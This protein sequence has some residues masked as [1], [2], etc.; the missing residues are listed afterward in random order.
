VSW[1]GAGPGDHVYLLQRGG[2]DLSIWTS[3]GEEVG[4]LFPNQLAYPHSVRI[5]RL[6][7]GENRIWITDMPSPDQ[8]VVP[9][10]HC[11]KEFDEA[12]QLL[13]TIGRCGADT[14]GSGLDPVQFD[15]VTDIAF[16]SKG[17][18]WI[19][20]GDIGGLNNRV[21]QLNA[22]GLVLQ[23]WSA[24][25]NQPGSA[26]GQFNLPHALDIDACDRVFIADTLNHRVQVIRT[27]GTFLQQLQC[28]GADGVYGLRLSKAAGA[29]G[30]FLATTSSPTS[31][32]TGGTVRLFQVAPSCTAPLPMP[33]GC[34]T[35]AQ[36]TVTLPPSPVTAL[37][38]SIDVGADGG[39]YIATLGG[40]LPPQKWI[41]V[42]ASRPSNTGNEPGQP[43]RER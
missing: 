41:P 15:K 1:L 36:W 4:G 26:P 20:D 29:G 31:S 11:V 33:D 34:M 10:G 32:P 3:A 42:E 30:A 23:V 39:L 21:L 17:M 12:G 14:G 13:S 25:G 9:V 18:R 43:N 24:P 37:L 16:D 40:D 28:F 2:L 22:D 19:S 6:A 7:S 5:Q 27:D 8:Q 35:T 38:H